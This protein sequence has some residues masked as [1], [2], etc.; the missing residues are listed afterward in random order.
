MPRAAQPRRA[1]ASEKIATCCYCGT[2]AVLV[3][4]GAVRH[5]LTCAACGAPIRDMK[6][7]PRAKA[8]PRRGLLD[9]TRSDAEPKRKTTRRPK[10][11]R[12]RHPA[13]ILLREAFDLLDDVFD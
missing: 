1:M 13:H 10:R 5:E 9:T 3:L 2:R 12:S 7:L 11:R 4:R 6:N 8:E